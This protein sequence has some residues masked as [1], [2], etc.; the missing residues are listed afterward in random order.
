MGDAIFGMLLGL[1]I[2]AVVALS[3]VEQVS[4]NRLNA[5]EEQHNIFRCGWVAQPVQPVSPS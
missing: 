4:T 5:C 2:G 1:A 3:I